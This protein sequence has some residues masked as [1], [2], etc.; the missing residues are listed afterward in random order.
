MKTAGLLIFAIL[1]VKLTYGQNQSYTESN[2]GTTN[3]LTSTK[4]VYCGNIVVCTWLC[5]NNGTL[6]RSTNR[7]ANWIDARGNL[8]TTNFHVIFSD[9]CYCLE[10]SLYYTINGVPYHALTYDGGL[11]WTSQVISWSNYVDMEKTY[12]SHPLYYDHLDE[13]TLFVYGDPK[14][15]RWGLAITTNGGQTFDTA[16]LYIPQ[17]GSEWGWNNAMD[18]KGGHIWFG[19]NNSH[20]YRGIRLRNW[21]AL[22][23]P[24]MVNSY[25]VWFNDTLKGMVGGENGILFTTNG[26]NS[27]TPLPIGGSGNVNGICS[28]GGPNWWAVRGPNIF[29]SSNTGTNWSI[30]YTA[31]AGNYNYI[32]VDS[33]GH[34]FVG[35]RDNG[36]VTIGVSTIGIQQISSEVPEAFRLEQNYPNPFNPSTN[37]KFQIA[38]SS[39]AKITIY[40]ISGKVVNTLVNEELKAGTYEVYFDGTNYASGVYYYMLEAGNYIET[41]KMVLIK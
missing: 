21:Q 24:G 7:G 23:T 30:V 16:G 25:S 39:F 27:F 19:T 4:N 1:F 40:D 22:P 38:K 36:G 17:I 10:A 9:D 41:K 33:T 34:H 3:N 6:K 11:S 13:D 18:I 29:Y 14:N 26:G 37:I 2:S 5:G 8:P 35:I 12:R 28:D 20:I 15:A 32:I 31:P